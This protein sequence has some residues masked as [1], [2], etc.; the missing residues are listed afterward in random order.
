MEGIKKWNGEV[1]FSMLDQYT[2]PN[3]SML[4]EIKNIMH[5]D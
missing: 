4:I 5:L 1:M 3:D 2:L